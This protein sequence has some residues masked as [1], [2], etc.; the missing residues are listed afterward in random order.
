MHGEGIQFLEVK[1]N[2]QVIGK[3]FSKNKTK[4][5][6]WNITS[7]LIKA[8]EDANALNSKL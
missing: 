2:G 3:I 7:T 4:I 6:V 5:L 1:L 8:F